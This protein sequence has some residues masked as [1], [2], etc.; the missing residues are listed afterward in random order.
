MTIH[1]N[2]ESL[3]F[4]LYDQET[5]FNAFDKVPKFLIFDSCRKLNTVRFVERYTPRQYS[6]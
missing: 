2:K 4:T 3:C 5:H 1:F 6:E